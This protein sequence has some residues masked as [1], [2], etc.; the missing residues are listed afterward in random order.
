MF[1]QVRYKP[2]SRIILA[3][4]DL[5]TVLFILWTWIRN[6]SYLREGNSLIKPGLA[7]KEL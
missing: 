5:N 2:V 6:G 1:L 7:L 4:P 3:A